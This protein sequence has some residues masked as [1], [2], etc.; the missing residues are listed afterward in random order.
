MIK[1]FLMVLFA[2]TLGG[3]GHVLLSKGMRSVGDMTEAGSGLLVGM[4]LR[5]ASNPWVI[6]GVALQAAFFFTYLTLL[7]RAD[8]T[9]VLPLTAV[10]YVVVTLLAQAFLGETVSAARWAGIGFVAT[11]IVLIAR[12]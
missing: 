12:T 4:A 5:A 11:G 6:L 3:I 1:T 2:A 7:S 9:I 10:D 8:I